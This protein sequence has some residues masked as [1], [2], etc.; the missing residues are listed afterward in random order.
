MAKAD[1]EDAFRLI[2]IHPEYHHLLGFTWKDAFYVD[3]CLPMGC[4]CSCQIF[5]N[6]STSLQWIMTNNYHVRDMAHLLDDFFFVGPANAPNCQNDLDN[7]HEL[8]T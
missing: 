7:F 3:T 1:I 8:C 4:S 5:E 2:P 6:F